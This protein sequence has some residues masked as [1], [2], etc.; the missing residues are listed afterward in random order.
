M[1]VLIVQKNGHVDTVTECCYD[2]CWEYVFRA[3]H[4]NNLYH[5]NDKLSP[6]EIIEH[7][8]WICE[9]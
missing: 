1:V 3:G 5:T 9:Q 4:K 2:E 8:T 7:Y 6:P